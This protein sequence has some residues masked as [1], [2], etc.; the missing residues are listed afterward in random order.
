MENKKESNIT[1][2]S[3]VTPTKKK[4]EAKTKNPLIKEK[5][6]ELIRDWKSGYYDHAGLAHRY[7][8]T[9]KDVINIVQSDP[10]NLP[11]I[12]KK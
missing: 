5:Q 10:H 4:I 9:V 2:K 3:R 8:I 12:Y 1:R 7:E 11:D 6:R